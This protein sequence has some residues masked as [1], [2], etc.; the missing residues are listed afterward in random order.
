MNDKE[1]YNDI[2]E[3]TS[4][5]QIAETVTENSFFAM[6][7]AIDINVINKILSEVDLFNLKLNSNEITSVHADS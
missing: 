7:K 2:F 6:E 3:T 4:G 1:I 5:K